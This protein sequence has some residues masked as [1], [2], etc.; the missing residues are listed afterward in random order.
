MH[1]DRLAKVRAELVRLG[2]GAALL[3]DPMNIRY[4]TGTRNMQVWT[5]HSPGRYVFVPVDGP[6]VLFEFGTTRHLSDGFATIDEQRVSTSAF[7]FLAGPTPVR[8]GRAVGEWRHR[9]DA[10]TRRARSTSRP[11]SM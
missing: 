2:Y 7:F 4:A 1:A 3:S 8:E 6:V 11:R 5:M 10:R 9:A